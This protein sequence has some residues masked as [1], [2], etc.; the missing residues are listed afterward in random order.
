MKANLLTFISLI[1]IGAMVYSQTPLK[2]PSIISVSNISASFD[3]NGGYEISWL[4]QE[5]DNKVDSFVIYKYKSWNSQDNKPQYEEVAK[6]K[7]TG[8]TSYYRFV[9]TDELNKVVFFAVEAIPVNKSL[10]LSS[11]ENLTKIPWVDAPSNVLLTSSVDTCNSLLILRWNRYRGWENVSRF[12]FRIEYAENTG[13]PR[14][15]TVK[16]SDYLINDTTLSL[17]STDIPNF[18][19]DNGSNYRFRVTALDFSTGNACMSNVISYIPYVPKITSY[20]N[21][22]GTRVVSKNTLQITFSVEPGNE[23]KNLVV[24]RSLY[25]SRDYEPVDTIYMEGDMVTFSD[26]LPDLDKTHYYYKAILLNKCNQGVG[27]LESN[28]A[29]NIVLTLEKP[30]SGSSKCRLSWE[31]Y[32]YF[33]GNVKEYVVYRIRKGGTEPIGTTTDNKFVDDLSALGNKQVMEDICYQVEAIEENNPH[34]V[35]GHAWSNTVC[36]TIQANVEMPK[37]L[38]LGDNCKSKAEIPFMFPASVFTPSKFYMAIFDRWGT[39][40]FETEKVSEGWD[41]TVKGK[42]VQQGAYMYFIRFSGTDNVAKEQKGSFVV[43]CPE[44]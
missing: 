8:G 43:I 9:P 11:S 36:L 16:G 42:V 10:Y 6:I 35:N 26:S 28:V 14:I 7:N 17:P 44:K 20:I 15:I 13:T 25:D 39:K 4:N 33:K 31:F 41:G 12:Y 5:N 1:G 29:T 2:S 18:S 19:F 24:L 27:S 21:A 30:V 38:L 40:V 23:F 37:Y 32:R 22:D 34:G 3:N